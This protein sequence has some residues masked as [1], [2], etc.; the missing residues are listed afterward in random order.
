MREGAAQMK[1]IQ[2]NLSWFLSTPRSRSI[3][4]SPQRRNVK[5]EERSLIIY[6]PLTHPGRTTIGPTA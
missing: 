3:N 6:C 2:T 4:L 5:L 1:A